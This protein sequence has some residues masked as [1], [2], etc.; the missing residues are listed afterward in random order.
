VGKSLF[1]VVTD[2]RPVAQVTMTTRGKKKKEEE[3]QSNVLFSSSFSFS[4]ASPS[5]SLTMSARL[6]QPTEIDLALPRQLG[7]ARQSV[8]RKRN[9]PEWVMPGEIE[10]ATRLTRRWLWPLPA[11]TEEVEA[12]EKL[13]EASKKIRHSPSPSVN[14]GF[15]ETGKKRQPSS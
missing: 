14:P 1:Y 10:A 11:S 4:F 3:E 8:L 2:V 12:T 7:P 5:S 13:D 9:G 6:S 15:T